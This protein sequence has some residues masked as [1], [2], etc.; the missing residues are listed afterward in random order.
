MTGYWGVVPAAG[1]GER[2]GA[3]TRK[4]Y[5]R[6]RGACLIDHS[7]A[8]LLRGKSLRVVVVSLAEDDATWP[9]TRHSG[10]PRVR[11]CGGGPSRAVSVM[12]ALDFLRE[13]AE[14]DDWVIVHDAVRPC[15]GRDDI[16]SLVATLERDRVGGLLVAPVSDTIKQVFAAGAS[17][18][19]VERTLERRRVM[20]ALTPQM[21]RFGLLADAI[22][23]ALRK[24]I[25]VGD[26]A[27]AM[28]LAGHT[29]RAVEGS[30]ANL[31]L[32]YRHELP[33]V[34]SWLAD[35]ARRDE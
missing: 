35:N 24:G 34:E 33:L 32:T 5:I 29:V 20:R 26:E 11:T 14:D 1:S 22:G 3:D 6:V 16:E 28:E 13:R 25:E 8:A 18:L 9:R 4:Q 19:T 10:D 21:F 12:R 23:D 7:L 30:G 2:F 15:L 17:R 31:K 27:E